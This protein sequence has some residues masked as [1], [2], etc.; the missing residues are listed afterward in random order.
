[1]NSGEIISIVAVCLSFLGVATSVYFSTRKVSKESEREKEKNIQNITTI[2]YDIGNV[3]S[4]VDEIKFNIK[5]INDRMRNDHDKLMEHDVKIKNIE[6]EV[7]K[8]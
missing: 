7:F 1:M 2:K 3:K 4:G 6:N 5:N 8:K